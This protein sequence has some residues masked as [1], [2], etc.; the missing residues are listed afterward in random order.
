VRV[1]FDGG[2][3]T[4][5]AGV[6]LLADVERRL[7]LAELLVRCLEDPRVP[8]RVHHT[9]AEMIRFRILLIA[10]GY[11]DANVRRSGPQLAT[12][13]RKHPARPSTAAANRP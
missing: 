3:L 9:V 13:C 7:R 5:D 4:S 12:S 8:E 11:P 2:C 10:A 1:V 6:L